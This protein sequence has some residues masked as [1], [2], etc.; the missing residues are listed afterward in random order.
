MNSM[1]KT[2]TTTMRR[3]LLGMVAA[4][5][6][7]VAGVTALPASDAAA[8]PCNQYDDVGVEPWDPFERGCRN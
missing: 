7:A 8:R 5:G 1:A 6:I 3:V 4:L 2:R